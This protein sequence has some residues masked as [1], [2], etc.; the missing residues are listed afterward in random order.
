MSYKLSA[1]T[2]RELLDLYETLERLGYWLLKLAELHIADEFELEGLL[3][4]AGDE[5]FARA[6]DEREFIPERNDDE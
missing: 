5:M 3:E 4:S 2:D 6:L 1:L